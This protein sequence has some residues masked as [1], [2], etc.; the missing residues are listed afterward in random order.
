MASR[1]MAMWIILIDGSLL[2]LR[3]SLPLRNAGAS[4]NCGRS[5][6]AASAGKCKDDD[7]RRRE[8]VEVWEEERIKCL[9][10]RMD[11]RETQG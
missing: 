9:Q 6:V 4:W 8:K 3:H 11:C 2:G 1:V 7:R 10:G 5:V